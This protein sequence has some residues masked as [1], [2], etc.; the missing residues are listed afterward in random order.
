LSS[1]RLTGVAGRGGSANPASLAS[2]N[3]NSHH[4]TQKSNNHS[5]HK[6]LL[7]KEPIEQ[8]HYR[9]K[10]IQGKDGLVNFFYL[11]FF[12]IFLILLIFT[13]KNI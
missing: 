10:T 5:L 11:N 13:I 4:A 1:S 9:L 6:N 3:R 2:K 8:A 12:T 7:V